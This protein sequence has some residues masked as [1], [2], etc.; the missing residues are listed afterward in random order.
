MVKYTLI[1]KLGTSWPTDFSMCVRYWLLAAAG[2]WVAGLYKLPIL[3]ARPGSAFSF[4]STRSRN[5]FPAVVRLDTHAY[6]TFS[7]SPF[8]QIFLPK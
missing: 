1:C 7:V 4:S 6:Y 5:T 8:Y 3:S 2:G